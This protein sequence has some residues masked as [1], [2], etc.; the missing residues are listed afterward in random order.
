V[1]NLNFKVI[2]INNSDFEVIES[3]FYRV[4]FKFVV[5]FFTSSGVSASNWYALFNNSNEVTQS[6]VKGYFMGTLTSITIQD[7]VIS[8]FNTGDILSVRCTS[9]GGAPT[10]VTYSNAYIQF[11][12]VSN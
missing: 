9:A 4:Y 5:M 3:G 8:Y 6:A 2:P 1:A 10:S 11:E 12:K 7:E